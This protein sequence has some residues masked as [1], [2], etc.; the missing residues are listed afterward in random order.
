[1]I[2][3]SILVVY[4]ITF[5]LSFAAV[6][7]YFIKKYMDI[8]YQCIKSDINFSLI[9]SVFGPMSLIG[10]C[11]MTNGFEYG[12]NWIRALKESRHR[13]YYIKDRLNF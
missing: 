6:L 4:L 2:I 9:I 11:I 8:S 12:F 5:Y 1:M 3:M 10:S 7:T 13:H